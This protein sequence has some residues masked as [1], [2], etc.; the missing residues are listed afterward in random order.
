MLV[1]LLQPANARSPMLVALS[2]IVYEVNPAGAN[3]I[4]S[5]SLI[6]YL[7]SLDANLPLNDFRLLQ[8]ANAPPPM[9][10]T[11]LGIV[12]LVRLSQP[13]NAQY[14]ML[15]TLSGIVMLFRLL[16]SA[17]A[18]F[19][20]LVTLSGIVMLVKLLQFSN[21]TSPMLVTLLGIVMLVRLLQQKNA[22]YPINLVPA[23][24]E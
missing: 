23:L 12:M 24:I 13:L 11:L 21:A 10:V 18:Q 9:L 14:P 2:G 22:A 17:N 19:P 1:R 6:K 7:P 15:V 16:Q 8:P 5:P 3:V 20:M 4:S